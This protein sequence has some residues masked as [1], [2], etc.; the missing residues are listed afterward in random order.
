MNKTLCYSAIF[1]N[2]SKNVYRCLNALKPIIDFVCIC[3]TG[4]TDNTIELIEQWGKENSVPTVV[5][6]GPT[7][8]F[9]NFGY[10]RT[11][12]YKKAVSS[13]PS[14]DYLLLVDADMVV[15][16]EPTFDKRKLTADSYMI[17]QVTEHLRYYNTRLISTRCKWECVGVTHEYWEGKPKVRGNVGSKANI[18]L[19]QEKTKDIWIH[20]IGD[21]GSKENKFKRDIRLLTEGIADST[22]ENLLK[23]RYMFYLANSY[24]DISEHSKAVEWYAKRIE[25]GGWDEEIFYSYLNMGKCYIWMGNKAKATETLLFAWNKRPTRAEPLYELSKLYREME[26]Y[27]VAYFFADMGYRIKYPEKDT[28]FIVDSVYKYLFLEEIYL[29]GFYNGEEGKKKGKACM[30]KILSMKDKIPDSNYRLALR[31]AKFYGINEVDQ[32]IADLK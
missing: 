17:E 22:T 28:L 18:S 25:H 3:D 32:L 8:I 21:G 20:D 30:I 1:K 24:K 16:I 19:S 29:T 12:A 26:Q 10:N 14:A 11:L 6:S 27:T 9:K 31:N 7:Q 15:K 23:G 13:F 5:H 4:S 2:E